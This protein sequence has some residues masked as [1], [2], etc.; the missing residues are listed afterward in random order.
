[1][2]ISTRGRYAL[3]MMLDVSRHGGEDVPVSL[4][5]VAQRTGISHGYLEQVALALKSARLV[6]GV[7]G[8]HGGYKLAVPARE[9]SIRQIIEATIGPICVVDLMLSVSA[10]DQRA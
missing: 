8:R 2:K 3:R 7:A 5:S 6:R 10:E 1:M 4:A 9:I